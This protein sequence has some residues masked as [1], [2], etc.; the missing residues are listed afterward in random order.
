M[1]DQNITALPVSTTPETSDQLLL[2][3][4]TEEKLIDYDKLADA[5]LNKLTSKKFSLDQGTMPLISALNQLNS[6]AIYDIYRNYSW[7]TSH[8]IDVS[9]ANTLLLV[10]FGGTN[11]NQNIILPLTKTG[12]DAWLYNAESISKVKYTFSCKN[13]VITITNTATFLCFLIKVV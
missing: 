1:A 6:K 9:N 3:G 7:K 4:A 5:I 2:V 13:N 10:A 11:G 8:S 12:T